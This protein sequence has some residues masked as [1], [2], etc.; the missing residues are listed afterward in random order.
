MS[1]SAPKPRILVVED[2]AIVSADIQD[3]LTNFG[4]E[5]VGTTDSGEDSVRL[6]R[7]LRPSLTLMD[8]MLSGPM[9]GAAAAK[10]IREELRIPVV[11]LTANSDDVTMFRARDTDP[12]GYVLKPFEDRSLRIAIEMALYKHRVE[13]EREELIAKLQA[14]LEHVKTLQ[15]MLPIC[16]W[17]KKVRDDAGYWMSVDQYL[18]THSELEF[19]H[20]VCPTCAASM[21]GP[22]ETAREKAKT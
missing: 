21:S 3:H 16:A 9:D 7:E 2:E 10:Q 22:P 11:F 1:N 13:Q 18:R 4:Y 20:G 6:A 5:V 15:G 19:S 17:C 14:A 12:F 8:I